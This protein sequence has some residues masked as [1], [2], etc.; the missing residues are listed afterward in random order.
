M[1]TS[2]IAILARVLVFGMFALMLVIGA[3]NLVRSKER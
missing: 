3:D 1:L 2:A